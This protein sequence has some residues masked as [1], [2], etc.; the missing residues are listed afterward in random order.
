[1]K[2]LGALMEIVRGRFM[3]RDGCER[4]W[5]GPPGTEKLNGEKEKLR[6]LCA[7]FEA[8]K[9]DNDSIKDQVNVIV[10]A[11]REAPDHTD[12]RCLACPLS[13]MQTRFGKRKRR[14]R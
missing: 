2:I 1:M 7:A 4:P 14:A 12:D 6:E 11:I 13:K 10:T 9:E 8:M 5:Q 3:R